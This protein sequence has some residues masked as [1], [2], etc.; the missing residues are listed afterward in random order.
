MNTESAMKTNNEPTR[1]IAIIMPVYN[2]ADTIE[3][4]VRELHEKIVRKMTNTDLWAFEDG[5]VDGT[6]DVLKKL[7]DE[8]PNFHAVMEDVKKGY[9]KAMKEAFAAIDPNEYEF[10]MSLDSDGQYDPDD[11]FKIWETMQNETTDIVM[12]KRTKRAE[13]FY[14]KFLSWGLRVIEGFMFPLPCKD[15]TSVMRLMRVKTAQ[16]IAKDVKYS[17]YNFWLEFTARMSLKKYK[18]I[19]I[20]IRYRERI[21]GSKVYSIK[22]IPKVI[23]SEFEALRAVKKEWRENKDSGNFAENANLTIN[24]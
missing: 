10:I 8:I 1:R 23:K 2:E 13:P 14:R 24:T 21:G 18:V 6:K 7:K 5:S 17:K 12:G 3:S 20:P 19:E 4:T 11:F 16:D 22:K 15:V 9:P